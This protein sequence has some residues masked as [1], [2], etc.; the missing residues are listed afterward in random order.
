MGLPFVKLV[1][2]RQSIKGYETNYPAYWLLLTCNR[3]KVIIIIATVEDAKIMTSNE[4]R[5]NPATSTFLSAVG[6]ALKN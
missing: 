6:L 1:S 2:K 5:Y 4:I 3:N